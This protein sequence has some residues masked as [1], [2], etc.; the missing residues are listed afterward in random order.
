MADTLRGLRAG[1]RDD[2]LRPPIGSGHDGR[3]HFRAPDFRVVISPVAS[4]PGTTHIAL[5]L[6]A[7]RPGVEGPRTCD[8]HR[9]RT[10]QNRKMQLSVREVFKLLNASEKTIYRSSRMSTSR[11]TNVHSSVERNIRTRS[12]N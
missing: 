10:L 4:L 8:P 9:L 11:S 3:F 7:R 12:S 6:R 5:G 1:C 2:R